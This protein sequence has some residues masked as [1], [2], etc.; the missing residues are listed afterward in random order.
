MN[1]LDEARAGL[2]DAEET[3]RDDG[4][5]SGWPGEE[6]VCST[7]LAQLSICWSKLGQ[8][9]RAKR[10]LEYLLPFQRPS[11][12]F[13]G[14]WGPGAWYLP[15]QEIGWAVKFF[16]DAWHWTERPA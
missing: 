5:V 16:L 11:G 9:E 12:G 2:R 8:P 4:S 14:S 3:Q 7:G 6:W 15:D 10:A 13:L 1:R